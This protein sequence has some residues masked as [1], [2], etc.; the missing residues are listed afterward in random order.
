M[1]ISFMQLFI[2]NVDKVLYLRLHA[3]H[4]EIMSHT[5]SLAASKLLNTSSGC[6]STRHRVH[7][8]LP[9]ASEEMITDIR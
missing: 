3:L 7:Y 5:V 6:P 9:S 8:T 4:S 1:S 2:M